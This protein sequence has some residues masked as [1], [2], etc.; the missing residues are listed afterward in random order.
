M[1]KRLCAFAIIASLLLSCSNTSRLV[2]DTKA[3]GNRIRFFQ[4]NFTKHKK[5]WSDFYAQVDSNN[6]RIYYNF[7]RNDINKTYGNNDNVKY[8][9]TSDKQPM[10][11]LTSIDIVVFTNA[12]KIMDS[13]NFKELKRTSGATGYYIEILKTPI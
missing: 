2:Y 1:T 11:P 8:I 10:S 3:D 5:N 7:F 13:L 4:A 9:L 6:V 12:N